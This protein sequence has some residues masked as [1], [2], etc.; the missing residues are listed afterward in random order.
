MTDEKRRKRY[1]LQTLSNLF[2]L[3]VATYSMS[4]TQIFL[5]RRV[6]CFIIKRT[7]NA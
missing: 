4:L 3:H 1:A 5:C 7:S 2:A 6:F